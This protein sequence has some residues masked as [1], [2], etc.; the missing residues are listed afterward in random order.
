MVGVRPIF[1]PASDEEFCLHARSRGDHRIL[2]I[3][4]ESR[5]EGG[6]EKENIR[7]RRRRPGG[8]RRTQENETRDYQS[9]E[10]GDNHSATF[11]PGVHFRGRP[12]QVSSSSLQARAQP[13]STF[14]NGRRSD[15]GTARCGGRRGSR[16]GRRGRCPG[17]PPAAPLATDAEFT[18]ATEA[19]KAT[20]APGQAGL[21]KDR[22]LK[23]VRVGCYLCG[24]PGQVHRGGGPRQPVHILRGHSGWQQSGVCLAVGQHKTAQDFG[25]A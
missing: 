15:R 4:R 13:S 16:R 9:P 19:I 5:E 21:V 2:D 17:P 25:K 14:N 11:P 18:A 12:P 24:H 22:N 20:K 3:G 1:P 10:G 23:S 8:G 6:E 7:R